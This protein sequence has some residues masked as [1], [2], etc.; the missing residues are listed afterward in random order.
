MKNLKSIGIVFFL[1]SIF[2]TSLFSKDNVRSFKGKSY[3]AS[4]DALSL[5]NKSEADGPKYSI[6]HTKKGNYIVRPENNPTKTGF[7]FYPGG[8]VECE[9]YLPIVTELA[10]KGYLTILVHMP[11]DLAVFSKNAADGIL[12]EFTDI[13]HWF[14]GGHSLGGAMAADYVCDKAGVFEGLVLFAGYSQRKIDERIKVLSLYCSCDEVLNLESYEKYRQNLPENYKEVI[15]DG[16][17]HSY[18]GDYGMQ[19]GDGIPKI[20]REEQL[21]T[22]IGE[23]YSFVESV[24]H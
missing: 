6:E 22:T 4:D 8:K 10:K 14:I 7:I 5:I 13:E 21:C 3:A 20:T 15:I 18:F 12:L 24:I 1:F 17:C 23:V 16:G 11:M 2:C 9:A 19:S